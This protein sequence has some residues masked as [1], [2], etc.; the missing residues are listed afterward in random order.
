LLEKIIQLLLA[1]LVAAGAQGVTT[2]SGHATAAG[3]DAA[4]AAIQAIIDRAADNSS[5]DLTGSD[6][7]AQARADAAAAKA[8]GQA[9]ADAAKAAAA[10]AKAAGQAKAAAAEANGG[11][12]AS[13]PPTAHPPVTPPNGPPFTPPGPPPSTP[14]GPPITPPGH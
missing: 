7:A 9:K 10:A 3:S 12:P 1:L 8:A 4:K 6:R 11:K 5:A 14:P 13:V 2:A